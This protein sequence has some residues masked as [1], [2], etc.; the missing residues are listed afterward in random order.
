MAYSLDTVNQMTQAEFIE[1]F[2]AIFEE[3]P[4]IAE[5][6]WRA[7]PFGS[8]KGLHQAMVDVVEA[9]TASAQ[10][11][12]IKAHPDLGSRAAMAEASVQEQAGAGIGQMSEQEYARFQQL[13]STYKRK[14]DF[15]FVMAVKGH[16]VESILR[17]FE[18]RL[19]NSVESERDQA[20]SE[21]FQIARFRLETNVHGTT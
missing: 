15:P 12:L 3:T 21:I 2:G 9:D 6:A 5:R 8:V 11:A 13:N 17:A 1:A 4:S 19:K 10:I 14:F 20:L 18:D 16:N 7:R